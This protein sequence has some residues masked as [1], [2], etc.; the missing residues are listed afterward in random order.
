MLRLAALCA[1]LLAACAPHRP[2]APPP[3]PRAPEARTVTTCVMSA[4]RLQKVEVQI[5]QATGDTTFQGR[6]FASAFPL[7]GDYAAGAAWYERNVPLPEE[8]RPQENAR[9]D[10]VKYGRPQVLSADTLMHV[11]THEGVGVYMTHEDAWI[12]DGIVWVPV[13][14]GC[15]FHHYQ[16]SG[17]GEWRGG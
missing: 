16:F 10:Y 14:P 7:T 3:P 4:G 6:P 9:G 1:L 11:S 5:S 2:T 15:W 13:R 17:V 12:N 8:V